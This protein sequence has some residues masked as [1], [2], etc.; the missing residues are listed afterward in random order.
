MPNS[1]R[2]DVKEIDGATVIQFCEGRITDP[3]EIEELGRE[4]YQVVENNNS[5]R[6]VL[7][8]SGVEFLS[9]PRWANCSP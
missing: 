9:M 2:L 5:P 8:F 4:L 3:L 7:D 1:R 6:L